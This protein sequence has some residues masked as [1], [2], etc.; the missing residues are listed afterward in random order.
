MVTHTVQSLVFQ[1]KA[2][3]F[4]Q[5]PRSFSVSA[6]PWWSLAE[7]D[8]KDWKTHPDAADEAGRGALAGA[9]ANHRRV[10]ELRDAGW[11]SALSRRLAE[12]ALPVVGDVLIGLGDDSFLIATLSF[13]SN[14]TIAG[15]QLSSEYGHSIEGLEPVELAQLVQNIRALEE[16]LNRWS[17]EPAAEPSGC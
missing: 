4:K 14:G 3:G 12:E 16:L 10:E 2:A 7:F 6:E 13:L 1:L 11:E 8:Q 15:V 17:D 5:V 9:Q